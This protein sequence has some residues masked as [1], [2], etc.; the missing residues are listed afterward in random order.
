MLKYEPPTMQE[1]YDSENK[2]L[3]TVVSLFAGAG[4]S[5]TG[6]RLAGGRVLA[7]N[8]FVQEAR[9]TYRANYKNTYIFNNDIRELTGK[10]ILDICQLKKG[11]LDILDGSP[12]CA[13]FSFSGKR[14]RSFGKI[15]LYSNKSQRVD[16]LFFEYARLVKELQPKIFIAENVKGLSLGKVKTLL[17]NNQLDMFKDSEPTIVET[18]SQCGYNVDYK[19]LNAADYGVLQRRE[20]LFIIGIR[21][22]LNLQP[23]FPKRLVNQEVTLEVAFQNMEEGFRPLYEE[24]TNDI[25]KYFSQLKEWQL[26]SALHP[27]KIGHSY[28]RLARA[29]ASS[30]ICQASNRHYIHYDGGKFLSIEE[31]KRIFS[32][33][34]D[35]IL[36]G[37]YNQ[38]WE[39][40]G[41]SVP[42]LLMKAVAEHLYNT[43]L[44][45]S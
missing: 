11:E 28:R 3:F 29:K 36:T 32:F 39:R 16:D 23:S 19:V 13:A 15:K 38:Q 10:K 9:D 44:R 37:S 43:I 8:E 45:V 21:K 34:D 33:P 17:V 31:V 24:D 26:V 4:G 35:F 5:S 2:E 18:L 7:I 30:T 41:R 1:V 40:L 6:Y 12:P 25:T 22:D 20:R 42:P 27:K 14:K